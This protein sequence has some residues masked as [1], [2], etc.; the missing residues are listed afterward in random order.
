MRLGCWL[1]VGLLIYA[2]YGYRCTRGVMPGGSVG[3][4]VLNEMSDSDEPHA[5]PEQIPAP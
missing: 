4:D 2:F 1:L 3:L 5:R